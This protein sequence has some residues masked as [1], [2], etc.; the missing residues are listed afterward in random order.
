MSAADDYKATVDS[1]T[2]GFDG[3]AAR[4]R[5]RIAALGEELKILRKRLDEASERH[6][7]ARVGNLLAWEDA[8]ELLWVEHWMTMRPFP[9]PD[10]LVKGDDADA[11]V[12]AVEAR[13]ADLRAAVQRRG[14]RRR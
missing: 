10:R 12:A 9:R 6:T 1:L 4:N 7:V 13:V 3:D 11:A 8:L 2:S 5:E 14:P